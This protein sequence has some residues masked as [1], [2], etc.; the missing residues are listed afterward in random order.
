MRKNRLYSQVKLSPDGN[1]IAY[2]SNNYGRYKIW[3]HTLSN[4]TTEKIYAAEP[5]QNRILDKTYPV[6]EWHPTGDALIFANER[7]G[8]L[9][10]N[11]YTFNDKELVSRK[12]GVDKILHMDFAP[13]AKRMVLSGTSMGK[14]NIC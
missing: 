9:K 7:K 12:L 3:V 10:Y 14:T 5:K 13:D 6:L 8:E 11:I 4:N 1:K 2:V